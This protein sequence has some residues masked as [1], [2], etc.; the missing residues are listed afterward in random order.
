M[1]LHRRSGTFKG[2][3]VDMCLDCADDFARSRAKQDGYMVNIGLLGNFALQLI[4]C[5][6]PMWPRG[7][8][9]ST[10]ILLLVRCTDSQDEADNDIFTTSE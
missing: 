5:V 9:L 8:T 4:V 1:S 6:Y 7:V 3:T 10:A 2:D